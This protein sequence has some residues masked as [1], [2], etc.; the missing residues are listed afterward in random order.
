MTG[1]LISHSVVSSSS[2]MN[3]F[4]S[5]NKKRENNQERS[6]MVLMKMFEYWII[7]AVAEQKDPSRQQVI[8]NTLSVCCELESKLY[9]C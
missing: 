1:E 7:D 8:V 5:T 6:E 9:I 4:L 2:S 3:K